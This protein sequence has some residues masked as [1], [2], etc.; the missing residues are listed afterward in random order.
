MQDGLKPIEVAAL[1]G[2]RGAVEIL[3]P[4]TSPI[5][6]ISNWSIDGII[7][8]MQSKAKKEQVHFMSLSFHII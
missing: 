1:R 5:L 8:Y 6:N 2:I 4:L 3:F 7:E